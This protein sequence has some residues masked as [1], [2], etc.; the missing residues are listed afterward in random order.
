MSS[1][2]FAIPLRTGAT[3][4]FIDAPRMYGFTMRANF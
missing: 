3:G 2:L 1:V 4:S